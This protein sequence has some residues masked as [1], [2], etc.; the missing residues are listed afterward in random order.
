MNICK[1][2]YKHFNFSVNKYK[3]GI[4]NKWNLFHYL[5]EKYEKNNQ[6]NLF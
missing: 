5:K 2:S 3:K 6:K 1:N 4:N